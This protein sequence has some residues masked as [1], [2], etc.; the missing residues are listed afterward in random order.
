MNFALSQHCSKLAVLVLGIACSAGC[1]EEPAPEVHAPIQTSADTKSA[2]ARE[3]LRQHLIMQ[4][5]FYQDN[6]ADIASGELPDS[7]FVIEAG[8]EDQI[9]TRSRHYKNLAEFRL[10]LNH[11]RDSLRTTGP[12]DLR[13]TLVHAKPKNLQRTYFHSSPNSAQWIA[14]IFKLKNLGA[15]TL[16]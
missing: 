3:Q 2:A 9:S 13:D 16:T 11:L 6:A 7:S 12:L 10:Y 5:K 4:T 15:F 8:D 1:R 14:S